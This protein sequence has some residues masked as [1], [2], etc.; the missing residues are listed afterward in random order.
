PVYSAVTTAYGN[1]SDTDANGRVIILL[2]PVVNAMTP[3]GASGFIAGFFYG[4]DLVSRDVCS[5][6]N[7][8]EIF[9]TLTADPA[10]Q[11]SDARSA[12][13]VMRALLPVLGH[14]FQHMISFGH[15]NNTDAL[16]LSEG[17][18]HHAEDVVADAFAA[19]GDAT[20]AAL[21]R[22]QNYLRANRYLRDPTF[23]SLIAEGGTGSLELRGAG[24]LF[25]KY[26]AGQFGNGI[27]QDLAQSNVSSV[28]NVVQQTGR[29][30]STLLA[31]WA[32]ALYADDAPEL[33]GATV[34]PEYTFPN[35]NLRATIVD[36]GGYLL[37]PATQ[38]Y[39]DFTFRETLPASSQ[40]YLRVEAQ[41]S[42]AAL[43]LNL[44]G[45]YGGPFGASAVPQLSILRL[46]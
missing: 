46:Q 7:S 6:T 36:A 25:V 12:I 30:W 21:F 26:L 2:T 41:G 27:L 23:T 28:T 40:A 18:A 5:G 24:W 37:R 8:A 9:Y 14:E 4:C 44:A 10:G 33:Q 22:S 38:G 29:T 31:N 1:P 45:Q 3:R 13:S 15:R 43:N 19:R 35:I 16:W 32:V 11:F 34:Q 39:G 20:N 42:A 17:L